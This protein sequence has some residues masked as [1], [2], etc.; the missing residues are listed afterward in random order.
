MKDPRVDKLADLLVNYSLGVQPRQRVMI[1]G[2]FGGEPLMSA[3]MRKCLQ[4][5]AYPFFIPY[6]PGH[7]ID[8]RT[9]YS[10]IKISWKRSMP[11]CIFMES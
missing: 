11:A 7:R 1:Q 5:G 6:A 2:D 9:F 4:V 8:S 10:H 3:V